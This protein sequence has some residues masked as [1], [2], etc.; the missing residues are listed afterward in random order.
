VLEEDADDRQGHF[1]VVSPAPDG[2]VRPPGGD[3]FDVPHEL[4]AEGVAD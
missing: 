3:V 1:R 4:L 2:N